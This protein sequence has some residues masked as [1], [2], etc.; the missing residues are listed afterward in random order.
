MRLNTPLCLAARNVGKPDDSI[1]FEGDVQSVARAIVT[2]MQKHDMPKRMDFSIG[3]TLAE[4]H[5]GLGTK[6]KATPIDDMFDPS[7]W[8]A[9]IEA[10]VA[11]GPTK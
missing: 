5:L 11:E 8:D 10:G 3:R 1:E 2:F 7:A 4:C 6:G 9:A